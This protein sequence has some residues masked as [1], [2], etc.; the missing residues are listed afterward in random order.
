MGK[1]ILSEGNLAQSPSWLV[2]ELS[3]E[4]LQPESLQRDP[5]QE[6]WA[7]KA[8]HSGPLLLSALSSLWNGSKG[9]LY[10]SD[11]IMFHFNHMEGVVGPASLLIKLHIS[12]QAFKPHLG[13]KAK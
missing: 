9:G 5:V 6:R 13:R 7:Y 4:S 3:L 2:A 12:C 1:L 8:L 11:A 10:L